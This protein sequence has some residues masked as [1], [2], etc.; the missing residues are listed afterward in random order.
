MAT[1]VNKTKEVIDKLKAEQ[2]TLNSPQDFAKIFAINKHME[3]VR[4][5]FQVKER[6]S[7]ISA[8]NII[9]TA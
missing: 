6:D 4:R 3:N 7:Q 8:S 5:D 9:L 2:K 1:T